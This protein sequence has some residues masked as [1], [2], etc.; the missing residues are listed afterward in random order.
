VLERYVTGGELAELADW[1]RECGF[2]LWT[3]RGLAQFFGVDTRAFLD[4][5]YNELPLVR[6]PP[7]YVGDPPGEPRYRTIDVAAWL[8]ELARRAP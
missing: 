4:P 8:D 1:F 3:P 2:P 6:R 7:R 5:P